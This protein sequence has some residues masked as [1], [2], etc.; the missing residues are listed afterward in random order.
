MRKGVKSA[1]RKMI[2]YRNTRYFRE[3]I[4]NIRSFVEEK[5]E[6][7]QRYEEDSYP[8]GDRDI[9]ELGKEDLIV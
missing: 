4:E 5:I 3:D 7:V 9:S 1:F 2:E 6:E 8:I